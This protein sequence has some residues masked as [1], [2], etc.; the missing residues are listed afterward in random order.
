MIRDRLELVQHPGRAHHGSH[1]DNADQDLGG[2]IALDLN[3]EP[4]RGE[5]Q[6]DAEAEDRQR[7]LPD[8]N[9]SGRSRFERSIGQS[10]GT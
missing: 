7:V 4:V 10:R 2:D 3:Q 1:A 6:E 8:Q 9:D 5:R